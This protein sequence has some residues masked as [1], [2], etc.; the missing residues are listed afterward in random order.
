MSSFDPATPKS[1]LDPQAIR[2]NCLEHDVQERIYLNDV[3]GVVA[4]ERRSGA[5]AAL[6]EAVGGSD[7]APGGVW[8]RW[9]WGRWGQRASRGAV[10]GLQERWEAATGSGRVRA[11]AAV[12]WAVGADGRRGGWWGPADGRRSGGYGG[13]GLRGNREKRARAG[14]SRRS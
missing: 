5:A 13:G 9:R 8:G 6:G 1:M 4:S 3:G 2:Y 14:S 10:G 11:G 12:V 7:G